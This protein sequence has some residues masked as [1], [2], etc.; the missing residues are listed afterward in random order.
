MIIESK[1]RPMEAGGLSHRSLPVSLEPLPLEGPRSFLMRLAEANSMTSL[2]L[3]ALR[4]DYGPQWLRPDTALRQPEWL[5]SVTT[6]ASY[7]TSNLRRTWLYEVGRVCPECL[8]DGN[9]TSVG[10]EVVFGDACAVHGT[11][12]VDRC[13][14]GALLRQY[15][16]RS[17]R[18]CACGTR[19]SGLQASQAPRAVVVLA[20]LLVASATGTA[21][22]IGSA[23]PNNAIGDDIAALTLP[24]LQALCYAFGLYGDPSAPR[25]STSWV[26]RELLDRSWAMTALAA[27]VIC[28]WPRAFHAVLERHARSHDNG[29]THHLHAS[30]G[31]LYGQLYGR[32]RSDVFDFVRTEFL[33]HLSAHWRSSPKMSTRLASIPGLKMNWVS[34]TGAARELGIPR[35]LIDGYVAREELTADRR[36]TVTGRERLMIHRASIE[37][38]ARNRTHESYDLE[39][40]AKR[41]GIG[42]RRLRRLLPVLFPDAWQALNGA[43][44]IPIRAIEE[45]EAVG[46]TNEVAVN[47][48]GEMI[49]IDQAARYFRLTDDALLIL[50]CQAGNQPP[51]ELRFRDP[52]TPGIGGW[53]YRRE[54][55]RAVVQNTSDCSKDS[56]LLTLPQLAKIWRIKQEVVY[57][58]QRAGL[59]MTTKADERIYGGNLISRQEVVRF[60]Q[61][62]RAARHIAAE[63]CTSPR[64]A[65]RKIGDYGLSPAVGA[66]DGCRQAFFLRGPALGHALDRLRNDF[67][68]RAKRPK[69]TPS[70]DLFGTEPVAPSRKRI[71][72][73]PSS[74]ALLAVNER[75]AILKASYDEARYWLA[76]D[77]RVPPPLSREQSSW[78]H[79]ALRRMAH[80]CGWHRLMVGQPLRVPT[81]APVILKFLSY[82]IA[83]EYP[84]RSGDLT[85]FGLFIPK[86]ERPSSAKAWRVTAKMFGMD[87]SVTIDEINAYFEEMSLLHKR[88]LPTINPAGQVLNPIERVNFRKVLGEL[89]QGRR[90]RRRSN[91]TTRWSR[92]SHD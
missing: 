45:F 52:G 18:C 12:L 29:G 81:S 1:K 30:F 54:V 15:R 55:I 2:Q 27:E 79:N 51:S 11:W 86:L 70:R 59:L 4:F 6:I 74:I 47:S 92:K 38:F 91:A 78:S 84:T 73:A 80:W 53:L 69:S 61:K 89:A 88:C 9:G 83:A 13:S 24:Q 44:R 57:F 36:L 14:C 76:E 5:R 40:A 50:I 39:R 71:T 87:Q 56:E 23:Y 10:A 3:R 67:H 82:Y 37:S 68:R 26:N 32:L 31:G 72:S 28:G 21:Y 7:Y 33:G 42:E 62:Y 63:F 64:H 25:I 41:L 60:E 16:L 65:I 58:L 75:G 46:P 34:A 35:S 48:A 66:A 19:L 17:D 43:W 8:C 49:S 85:R 20:K 90:N 22:D 77:L